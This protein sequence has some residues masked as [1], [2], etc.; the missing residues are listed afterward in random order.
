MV[1]ARGF[2]AALVWCLVVLVLSGLHQTVIVGAF[3]GSEIDTSKEYTEGI[4][5]SP[6]EDLALWYAWINCNGT[7]LIYLA[8]QSYMHRPPVVTFLGQHYLTENNEEAFVGNTLIGMDVYNDTNGNGVPDVH[9]AKRTSE[10]RY[11]FA[12]NSSESFEAIPVKKVML[13]NTPH[14]TWGVRY[15]RID[16][17]LPAVFLEMETEG[18]AKVTLDYL[19]FS[20]DFYIEG[21][22]SYLKTNFEIGQILE[23]IPL[24]NSSVNLEGLSL[25]LLYETV[26][27]TPKT[28]NV[29]V[30][31]Q[32]FNSMTTQDLT[33]PVESGE[34]QIENITTYEFLFGQNYTIFGN[35]HNQ[36]LPSHTIGVTS[37]HGN[38]HYRSAESLI[39][40]FE[41]V[42]SAMFP[43]ISHIQAPIN[44]DYAVSPL[45]YRI[46]YPEWSAQVLEHDPTYIAHLITQNTTTQNLPWTTILAIAI[47]GVS[48]IVSALLILKRTRKPAHPEN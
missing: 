2:A 14:Y 1:K 38:R 41:A 36:S 48:A 4:L 31:G 21:N 40:N 19:T 45:L 22:R 44:L 18:G 16:G 30:D 27:V 9:F 15:N 20:Y 7:Q 6:N 24:S 23:V 47:I 28:H 37:Q 5:G 33:E 8:Y 35:L 46:C 13:Q 17:F 11:N 10:I 34:I 3:S 25:S 26:V 43:K 32:P 12:V 39:L 42:L 29:V